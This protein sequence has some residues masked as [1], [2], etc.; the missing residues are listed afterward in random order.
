MLQN[1]KNTREYFFTMI[2]AFIVVLFSFE[3]IAAN[4]PSRAVDPRGPAEKTTS[5][6]GDKE[7]NQALRY[8][9]TK[10]FKDQNFRKALEYF[11]AAA[12]LGHSDSMYQLHMIYRNKVNI[13]ARPFYGLEKAKIWLDK[14]AQA[15]SHEAQ[16]KLGSIYEKGT[17]VL[18][19]PK[20]AEYYYRQ[21]AM[22]GS[23]QAERAVKRIEHFKCV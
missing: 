9:K 8:I 16:Y 14:A 23:W 21:A 12:E 11:H 3:S 17:G 7:F 6:P 18:K 13:N 5:F 15:G 19:D 20:K 2:V 4:N 10:N 1:N 22:N